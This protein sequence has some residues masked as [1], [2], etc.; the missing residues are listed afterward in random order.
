MAL[1][2]GGRLWPLTFLVVLVACGSGASGGYSVPGLSAVL[3]ES[4]LVKSARSEFLSL[5][6]AR[7]PAGE[8]PRPQELRAD[9][10]EFGH[11]EPSRL[12]ILLTDPG[13]AWLGL[14]HGLKSFGIPFMI[15]DSLDTALEHRVVLV[16]PG[17]KEADIGPAAL[18]ALNSHARSGGAILSTILAPAPDAL[19]ELFG[20]SGTRRNRKRF[21]LSYADTSFASGFIYPEERT[22]RL[23][24]PESSRW[25]LR[26]L[27]FLEPDEA[28]ARYDDGSAAIVRR[29]LGSGAAMA[30]GFDLG[31]YIKRAQGNRDGEANREYV[32]GFEPS[33]DTVLRFLGEIYRHYE[34]DALTLHPAPEGQPLSVI[35][36][37][38]VDYAGSLANSVS[39]ADYERSRGYGATY[40]LQT[41]Y[42]RD[43]FDEVFFDE[44]TP[45]LLASL[46]G[47][48]MELASHSVSHSDMF[49]QLPVGS[50]REAYPEYQ[51][52]II[53]F[54]YTRNAT[55]MGELR[56]SKYLIERYSRSTVLSFRPGFLANPFAL[57]Q[58][59]ESAGY[60]YSS[61]VTAND[62]MT[63][64]PYRQAFNRLYDSQ[65]MNYEFPVTVEDEKDPPM[66]GRVDEAVELAEKLSRYGGLFMILIHPNVL[67][68]KLRFLQEFTERVR[69]KAWWGTLAEFGAW[70]EARDRVELDV[71]YREG[72]RYLRL[73]APDPVAGLGLWL[74]DGESL[75]PSAIDTKRIGELTVL[76]LPSG[77]SEFALIQEEAPAAVLPEGERGH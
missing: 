36:S 67:D 41:K 7:G 46:E 50:F 43:F 13:A 33:M 77:V 49:A 60:R 12:A 44:R 69:D 59:L 76:N 19:A 23:G 68:D 63:H 14:A 72:A 71:V 42:F 27:A 4:P 62:V 56:V 70:W 64:L 30:F 54:F 6:G 48:G 25:R 28:I 11:G 45:Q 65:T 75:G 61:A 34:P 1:F 10:R 40:F 55:I 53:E 66:D 58:A 37:H 8:S 16:Y 74:R 22:I 57:P 29:S 18:D 5:P 2:V 15:T 20:F 3:P 73:T 17:F 47:L 32:N 52:R 39:Y 24:N 38:D 35:V 26:T 31:L 51:P 21:E 9:W